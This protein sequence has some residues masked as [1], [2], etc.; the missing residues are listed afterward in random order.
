VLLLLG[1]RRSQT[2]EKIRT[3]VSNSKEVDGQRRR[4]KERRTNP[5]LNTS[6]IIDNHEFTQSMVDRIQH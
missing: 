5:T 1:S 2:E 4:K 6:Q 3:A